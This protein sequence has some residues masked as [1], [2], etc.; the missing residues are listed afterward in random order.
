MSS[1]FYEIVSRKNLELKLVVTGAHLSSKFGMTIKEIEKDGFQIVKKIKSYQS[2]D[3]LASRVTGM[4][5]QLQKISETI[6]NY[7]LIL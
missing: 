4:G 1:I 2:N 7:R 3:T 5:L 6:K